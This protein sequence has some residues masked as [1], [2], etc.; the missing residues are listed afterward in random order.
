MMSEEEKRGTEEDDTGE[1]DENN[2]EVAK[3]E[4]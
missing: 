1:G 3:D 4:T 2:D